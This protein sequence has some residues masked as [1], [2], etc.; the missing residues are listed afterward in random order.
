M[1]PAPKS[2]IINIATIICASFL[3][4]CPLNFVVCS[5]YLPTPWNIGPEGGG[6]LWTQ[7]PS[8]API[9]SIATSI[10]CASFV[11]VTHNILEFWVQWIAYL[12]SRKSRCAMVDCSS[13]RVRKSRM[14]LMTFTRSLTWRRVLRG[15]WQP[16]LLIS[17]PINFIAVQFVTNLL[18]EVGYGS[19]E[20]SVWS[21]RFLKVTSNLRNSVNNICWNWERVPSLY[22]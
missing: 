22:L 1:S 7:E 18:K 10:V 15:E 17:L 11:H 12:G 16:D 5:H 2:Q 6:G 14:R 19:N 4:E 20:L 9:I 3:H 21:E 8:K 13:I